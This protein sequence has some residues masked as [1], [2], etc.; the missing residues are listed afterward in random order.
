MSVNISKEAAAEQVTYIEELF[1]S[2]L[3]V[4]S[5]RKIERAIESGRLEFDDESEAFTIRLVK[6][7]T[8]QNGETVTHLK[9]E[10]PTT[11]QMTKATRVKGEVEQASK[12]I[13]AVSGQP[14]A[15][16]ERLKMR[17]FA[18]AS[19]VLGFFA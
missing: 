10:E 17:D 13:A 14:T 8:L 19:M 11:E 2:Q 12:I 18:I 9:I 4:E 15:V 3:D 16:I 1:D 6:P 5:K 7:V